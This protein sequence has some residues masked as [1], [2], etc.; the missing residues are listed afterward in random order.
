SRATAGSREACLRA[1][2]AQGASESS[3]RAKEVWESARPCH[4]GLLELK[5]TAAGDGDV[6]EAGRAFS[7]TALRALFVPRD[8]PGRYEAEADADVLA[9]FGEV[10]TAWPQSMQAYVT[11]VLQPATYDEVHG[12]VTALSDHQKLA[13]WCRGQSQSV[14]EAVA[15]LPGQKA[16]V[17][18]MRA[19]NAMLHIESQSCS[20]ARLSA[21]RVQLPLEAALQAE[22]AALLVPEAATDVDWSILQDTHFQ[23]LVSELAEHDLLGATP[24]P[25]NN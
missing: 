12:A 8:L 15:D 22:P 2:P 9:T 16:V 10:A 14:K 11:G 7:P 3:G 18:W 13:S 24:T 25:G 4:V 23:Q 5:A 1:T 20:A 19:Q 21:W 6:C 17:F